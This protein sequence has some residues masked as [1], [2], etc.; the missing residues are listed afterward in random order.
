MKQNYYEQSGKMLKIIGLLN[1]KLTSYKN[2]IY[3]VKLYVKSFLAFI[4]FLFTFP[5]TINSQDINTTLA[6][7]YSY[8]I[9]FR[10]NNNT[11]I[12]I[13]QILAFKNIPNRLKFNQFKIGINKRVQK[14]ITIS[15][16]YKPMIFH[17]KSK[18]F[19][20]HQLSPS[21]TYRSKLFTLPLR[22]SFTVDLFLPKL[23]KYKFRFIYTL[24]YFF[25][26]KYLPFR[27]TPYIKFQL[28]YYLNGKPIKYY[29][30]NSSELLIKNS[31]NDFHR[32]RLGM[33]IRFRPI[34]HFYIT[35][36]YTLQK[37]F[38]TSLTKNRGLN[39][40]N[41]KHTKIQSPF[42]NYQILGLNFSYSIRK[43]G[44]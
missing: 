27:A 43:I 7:Y 16:F 25:R 15:F 3:T 4:I 20:Y 28:Y 36:Y 42:N 38:N 44:R 23:K 31:P 35:L 29:N 41:K 21:V 22:N 1:F 9:N 10:L 5:K 37:E 6:N 40:W 18:N 33:G 12:Y 34:K 11:K 24:K 32:F 39:I 14:N 13:G 30:V 26:N 17:G 8:N 2:H 19:L